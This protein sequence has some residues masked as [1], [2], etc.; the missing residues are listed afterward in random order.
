MD[1]STESCR[2]VKG[3]GEEI[4]NSPWSG[5]PKSEES[6][7]RRRSH[8]YRGMDMD[9]SS[10]C[11]SNSQIRVVPREI[12]VFRLLKYRDERLFLTLGKNLFASEILCFLNTSGGIL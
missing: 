12:M 5:C 6:R 11:A 8:R 1:S 9:V 3:R 4:W 10:E 2:Q 7:R